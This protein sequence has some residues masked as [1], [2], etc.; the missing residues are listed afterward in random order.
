MGKDKINRTFKRKKS[1][2]V[3]QNLIKNL[4]VLSASILFI[5]IFALCGLGKIKTLCSQYI[6]I[7]RLFA[8]IKFS[9]DLAILLLKSCFIIGRSGL[10]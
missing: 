7:S 3:M 8:I 2:L 10:I 5:G 9:I 4:F 1:L 6:G